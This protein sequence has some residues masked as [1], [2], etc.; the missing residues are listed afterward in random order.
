VVVEDERL[1]KDVAQQR[2][3]KRRETRLIKQQAA[4]IEDIMAQMG[5]QG[6][7]Q[8]VLN[9]VVK[10]DVQGSVEALRE[11]LTKLSTDA[12]KVN[13]IASGVGGI[14]ESD[15]T[16]ASASRALVIGFNVRADASARKVIDGAGVD[17]RYF[18]IIYDV[19]DQVKQVA[20][21]LLGTEIREEIIGVAQVRDVFR[22][23]KFGA[24]AGCMI[25]EGNVKRN[26][27]IRVLRDNVVIFQGEL[28]SLRRFKDAVDEVRNGM[29]CG[30]GVKQYNDVRPGDQIECYE[31]IEVQRTL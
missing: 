3:Q 20:S 14:T 18:S 4:K 30:I 6:D 2:H 16:L 12:V 10:A 13:V 7:G 9:V 1:A 19:I 28:E 26:K 31:R 25:I 29:E 5:Q 21:G 15:A 27:P 23:S 17:V 24:I 22:S 8:R 11:A